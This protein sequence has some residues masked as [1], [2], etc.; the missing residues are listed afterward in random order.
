[1]EPFKVEV[2]GEEQVEEEEDSLCETTLWVWKSSQS[3]GFFELL[4]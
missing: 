4:K 3:L 2:E 1:M